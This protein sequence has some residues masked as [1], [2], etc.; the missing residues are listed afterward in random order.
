[1][2]TCA[3]RLPYLQLSADEHLRI[4][5]LRRVRSWP[6]L[7]GTT[8]EH[9]RNKYSA[10]R[11]AI[12]TRIAA[13][14]QARQDIVDNV[15]KFVEGN[16]TAATENLTKLND[17]G[18][19]FIAKSSGHIGNLLRNINVEVNSTMQENPRRMMALDAAANTKPAQENVSEAKKAI[20]AAAQGA[21]RL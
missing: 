17:A 14:N 15:D 2:R 9:A 8:D 1:M 4:P 12:N 19:E 10:T 21:N 16:E 20:T 3:F 13:I 11:Q 6:R 18:L 7:L 5:V